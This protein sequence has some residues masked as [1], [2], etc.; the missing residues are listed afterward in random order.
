MATVFVTVGTTS[1]DALVDVI[2]SDAFAVAAAKRGVE[3]ITMQIGRGSRTPDA[4]HETAADQW[5]YIRRGVAF[6]VY[7][8]KADITSDMRAANLVISHAGG[9]E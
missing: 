5:V 8:Y 3:R 1:F 4:E 2:D 6:D 7:R 9:F